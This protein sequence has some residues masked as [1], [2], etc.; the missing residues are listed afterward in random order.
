SDVD[1]KFLVY[2]D[3]KQKNRSQHTVTR[4]YFQADPVST[5]QVRHLGKKKLLKFSFVSHKNKKMK[6]TVLL[7]SVLFLT[8][9]AASRCSAAKKLKEPPP[10]IRPPD[11]GEKPTDGFFK[12][13]RDKKSLRDHFQAVSGPDEQQPPGSV[14]DEQYL[15]YHDD[16]YADVFG[17]V[18]N[19]NGDVIK[20][21]R[22]G[23]KKHSPPPPSP[24]EPESED[25]I[26]S[27][28]DDARVNDDGD[29][30]DDDEEEHYYDEIEDEY[31]DYYFDRR[32]FNKEFRNALGHDRKDYFHYL[33]RGP[34]ND[35]DDDEVEV[36]H[37]DHG[38]DDANRCSCPC[39]K[40]HW[41]KKCKGSNH[42][43]T[44]DR[45]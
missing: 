20:P 29:N 7:V 32:V 44:D 39:K 8:T 43:E 19:A 2:R 4:K 41:H 33:R 6:I 30:D 27:D 31:G 21:L 38:D 16:H 5:E 42:D 28:E 40:S 37:G 13:P 35:D 14:K 3:I 34:L 36:E 11:L 12:M 22:G 23:E 24:S 10:K 25:C 26:M 17:Y 1:L 18:Y 9:H 45:C 15:D